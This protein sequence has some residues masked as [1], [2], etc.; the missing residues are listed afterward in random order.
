VE[1]EKKPKFI[2]HSGSSNIIE[3]FG[4]KKVVI[5]DTSIELC[6]RDQK[7]GF[8]RYTNILYSS[9]PTCKK[10]HYQK[11]ISKSTKTLLSKDHPVFL[12]LELTK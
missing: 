8:C 2:F 10:R 12:F 5:S 3:D 1:E 9:V 11:N 4:K 6:E 7:Y